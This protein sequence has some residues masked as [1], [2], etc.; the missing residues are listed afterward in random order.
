MTPHFHFLTLFPDAIRVWL[1]TSILGR[2]H[3]KGV[4]DFSLYQLREYSQDKHRSV[5]DAA[6]GGGGGMVLRIEP[7]VAALESI[8]EKIGNAPSRTI[9]FSPLGRKLEPGLLA[10]LA[11]PQHFI[12]IC[13]HY[14]GIDQ[15]FLDHFVD[16][17]VSLGDFVVTGGELP[18]V[19]FS[20]AIIRQL[21][22][23]LSSEVTSKES[24]SLKDTRSGK[25]L[26][27]FPH[28]TRPPEFRGLKVPDVLLSG[29][30]RRIADWRESES[31]RRTQT[32]RP[33]LLSD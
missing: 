24:F 6:Y 8:R 4:F 27:E 10:A 14:E 32:L 20:D 16:L 30:H 29:D 1:T 11:I 26:L 31:R 33:D 28:Y 25:P 13:G 3:E 15:R 9:Y 12:L 17:E 21:G 7:L 18:A 22:G 2:A 5:D 23:T 19:A